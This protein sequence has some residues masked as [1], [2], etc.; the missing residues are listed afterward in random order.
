MGLYKPAAAPRPTSCAAP[1]GLTATPGPDRIALTLE[2][3]VT[4][5]TSYQVKHHRAGRRHASR[6]AATETTSQTIGGLTAGTKYT[7]TVTASDGARTS[8]PSD[9]ATATPNSV[10]AKVAIT[11]GRW[12][13]GDMRIQ[14]T[15]DAAQLAARS[16]FF[17]VAADG[18]S[19]STTAV[20]VAGRR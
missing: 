15:T 16:P 9:A 4:G 11:V 8:A 14:G 13:N 17:K 20:G 7:F 3:G 6:A 18:K 19:A 5:A 1:T 2:R 12:K 10:E